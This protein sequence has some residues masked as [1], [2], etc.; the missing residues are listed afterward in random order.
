MGAGDEVTGVGGE[1]IEG[2]LVVDGLFVSTVGF[3]GALSEG[4]GDDVVTVGDTFGVF[5][6]L[7]VGLPGSMVGL[8]VGEAGER[9][10]TPVDDGDG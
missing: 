7:P 4:A 1:D 6:G 10:G 2:E 9:D 3:P 8:S 5:V